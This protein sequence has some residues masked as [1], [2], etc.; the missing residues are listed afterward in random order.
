M[1]DVV[2]TIISVITETMLCVLLNR[3]SGKYVDVVRHHALKVGDGRY[4][5]GMGKCGRILWCWIWLRVWM[6]YDKQKQNY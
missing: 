5:Y 3:T 6:H 1:V 2:G 4:T